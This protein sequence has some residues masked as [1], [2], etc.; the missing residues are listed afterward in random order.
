MSYWDYFF[1]NLYGYLDCNKL[2][3]L[4]PCKYTELFDLA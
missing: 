3:D 1:S 2:D 4:R